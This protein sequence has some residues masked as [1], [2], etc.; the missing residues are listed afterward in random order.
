MTKPSPTDILKA[1]LAAAQ[2]AESVD[3]LALPGTY[4]RQYAEHAKGD[5]DANNVEA[6]LDG[7]AIINLLVQESI[8]RVTAT[9]DGIEAEDPKAAIYNEGCKD[10]AMLIARLVGSVVDSIIAETVED[11]RY[12]R[13]FLNIV[14]NI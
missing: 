1:M 5:L 13:A 12:D 6:F 7:C 4:A 3:D 11:A 2:E 8:L 9:A 14:N 10:G